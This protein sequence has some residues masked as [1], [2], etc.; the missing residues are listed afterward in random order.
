MADADFRKLLGHHR[1]RALFAALLA[2]ALIVPAA[3]K[4]ARHTGGASPDVAST[5]RS[6]HKAAFAR[7]ASA[8]VQ[9]DAAPG[10][11]PVA[12]PAP[13]HP[14]AAPAPAARIVRASSPL[15]GTGTAHHR[16][17]HRAVARRAGR[18][19]PGLAAVRHV[20]VRHVVVRAPV[21]L[22]GAPTAT[23]G[24]DREGAARIPSRHRFRAH[25]PAAARRI[26]APR[27][28]RALA[29]AVM[30]AQARA[31][32]SPP[33]PGSLP[34]SGAEGVAAG[35]GGASPGAS[36]A[37]VLAL[38]GLALLGALSPGLLALDVLPWRS[39]IL[40]LQLERPG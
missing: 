38:A 1:L 12:G 5:S 36:A 28:D 26:V 11:A 3:A 30:A 19:R 37:A 4:A 32:V 23:L 39:A 15:V 17:Q 6:P 20:I 21:Y 27:R 14:Y 40:A 9:P 7:W 25:A 34:P 24:T 10:G 31:P 18:H 16:A 29:A 2:M 22:A 8:S 13:R 35:A 33:V